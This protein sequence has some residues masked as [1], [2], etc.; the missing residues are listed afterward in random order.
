MRRLLRYY[1]QFE[2]LSEQEVNERLRDEAAERRARGARARRAARPLAHDLARVPAVGRRQRDHLRRAPRAAPLPRPARR[3]SC[4]RE[5]AHHLGVEEE[6]IVVG[7]G[8]AQLMGA[9]AQAL[10][11]PGDE[12]VTPWPSYPLYPRRSRGAR[13]GTRSRSPASAPRPCCAPST[14]ARALVALCNPNDPTGELVARRRPRRAARRRCPSASSSCSTRRCATSSTPSRATPSLAL[15]ADHPRL[16]VFRTFSK[17]WGLAG[18]RCGYAVGGPGAEPLLAQLEPELGLNELAQAGAL[19]ALRTAPR[20]RRR[21]GARRSRASARGS[22]RALRGRGPRRR[23]EPGERAVGSRRRASTAPSSPRRLERAGRDRRARAAPLGDAARVRVTVPPGARRRRP[24][25][26]RARERRRGRRALK[27]ARSRR[28]APRV[29]HDH[30]HRRR[31]RHLHHPADPGVPGAAAVAKPQRGVNKT[32]GAGGNVAGKAPGPLGSWLRKPFDTSNKAANKSAAAGRK[33][34]EQ[35][36]GVAGRGRRSFRGAARVLVCVLVLRLARGRAPMLLIAGSSAPSRSLAAAAPPGARPRRDRAAREAR[37]ARCCAAASRSPA[38]TCATSTPGPRSTRTRRT[39]PA[40]PRRWRS[41]TRRRRRCCASA[42]DATL[43]TQV[44]ATGALDP[45]GR[46]ARRH[47]PQGRRR[48]DARPA[49]DRRARADDRRPDRDPPRRR[50]GPR[51]R[52]RL[53]QPARLVADR[54]RGRSRH[55][56]RPE[57][58]RGQPRLLEA[59]ARRRRRPR[60]G[61][62]GAARGERRRRRQERGGHGPGEAPRRSR[63]STRRAMADLIRLTNVPSDNFDAEMLLKDLG[64]HFGAGGHDAPPAPRVVRAQLATFGVHPRSSTAPGL[65]R[66]DRTTPR[67][68]VRLL[69]RMQGSEF[70]PSSAAR[71]RS[72]GGPGTMRRRMRGTVAQDRCQTKTGTL[73]AVSALAGYCQ[74]TGGRTVAFAML[75]STV[76]ITRAHGVQDRMTEAIATYGGLSAGT[77]PAGARRPAASRRPTRRRRAAAPA[78]RPARGRGPSPARRRRRR[79]SAGRARRRARARPPGCRGR[80]RRPRRRGRGRSRRRAA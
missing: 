27:P 30:D 8:I 35:D 58:R 54:L 9:A 45:H 4:A 53:R 34:R 77:A 32:F 80:R 43:H 70:A 23:P 21:P 1:R 79:R 14:T 78:G 33:G 26:A 52:V 22:P 6:R 39:S 36:A 44:V 2:G 46:L 12:L 72:S 73:R 65:S 18:L 24:R 63:A 67:Q 50:L 68:V 64:A 61:C 20:D 7:G 51:R 47:L 74:T 59:T 28:S 5:L 49:A 57:R 15:L 40:R 31:R 25:A 38:R 16:L 37:R 66:A 71:C 48:P 10:L 41:S 56:G 55:R 62:E 11:E 60:A 42:P 13:A 69:E 3:R 19:E 76:F 75:M 17:A 29:G